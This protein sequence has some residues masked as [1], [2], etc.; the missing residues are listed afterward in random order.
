MENNTKLDAKKEAQYWPFL[1]GITGA[2][3]RWVL[4]QLEAA[5]V[6][7]KVYGLT[8]NGASI[9]WV[10]QGFLDFA[11]EAITITDTMM[12]TPKNRVHF[13]AVQDLSDDHEFFI[14][15]LANGHEFHTE[16]LAS[17][18]HEAIPTP[19]KPV[20]DPP[21][22]DVLEKM[23]ADVEKGKAVLAEETPL[24]PEAPAVVTESVSDDDDD[25]DWDLDDDDELKADEDDELAADE[26]EEGTEEVNPLEGEEAITYEDADQVLEFEDVMFHKVPDAVRMY[27]VLSSNVKAIGAREVS[28]SPGTATVYVQFKQGGTIYRYNPIS[29]KAFNETLLD[30]AVKKVRGLVEASVGSAFYALCREPADKGD[31]VCQRLVDNNKWATVQ[32]KSERKKE[33]QKKAKGDK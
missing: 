11:Y 26:D 15:D 10:E 28:K 17:D 24:V 5:E 12:G 7:H 13:F 19:M 18:K 22:P 20:A 1:V 2:K 9:I 30:Q 6:P 32:P 25:D 14:R 29:L 31:V 3:A 4:A 8:A 23:E 16:D 21:K 33:I 27:E